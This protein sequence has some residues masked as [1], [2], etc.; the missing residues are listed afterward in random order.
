MKS[1]TLVVVRSDTS[2][3]AVD[4]ISYAVACTRSLVET[5]GP[6]C[7]RIPDVKNVRTVSGSLQNLEKAI[8]LVIAALGIRAY[9]AYFDK[10]AHPQLRISRMAKPILPIGEPVCMVAGLMT[11]E[12]QN[13][14]IN[15]IQGVL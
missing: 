2:M 5:Y 10:D 8:D 6:E 9:I 1:H 12:Q 14:I 7:I 11:L 4:L 13:D 3:E 15:K